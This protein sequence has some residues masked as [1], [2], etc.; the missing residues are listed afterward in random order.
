MRC[1]EWSMRDG[2]CVGVCV[3]VYL[4]VVMLD[5]WGGGKRVKYRVRR[6]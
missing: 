2:V 3:C 6:E 5:V 1:V 4:H